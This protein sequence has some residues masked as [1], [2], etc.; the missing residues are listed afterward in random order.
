MR[1]VRFLYKL[2]RNGSEYARLSPSDENA[3]S[4]S[5]TRS[6]TKK[7]RFSGVFLPT[8][9]GPHG[10]AKEINWYLDEIQ[11]VLVVDGVEHPLSVIMPSNPLERG[12]EHTSKI[13]VVGYDRCA[14]V[15]TVH[16]ESVIHLSAGTLYTTAIKQ[17]LGAAGIYSVITT[18]SSATL[19][20]DREDWSVGTSLLK[21][22]NNLLAEINYASLWFDSRGNAIL[23]PSV[24]PSV[25]NINHVLSDRPRDSLTE[26]IERLLPGYSINTDVYDSPNVFICICSN[27]DKDDD[28]VAVA[29]NDDPKSPIST[30]SRGRRICKDFHLNNIASIE[31]LEAFANN[32]CIESMT[33]E[34]VISLTTAL[35]PGWGVYDVTAIHYENINAICSEESWSMDL[36]VGGEMRHDLKKVV[37]NIG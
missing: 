27:P 3:T 22:V 18:P 14:R 10:G 30:V 23:Q 1:R 29:V 16:A 31:D 12:G 19:Q 8:A 24:T 6:E 15:E 33:S 5:M 34:Q 32:R 17:I 13:A 37:Y 9:I 26:K 21:V 35:L 7:M 4:L 25:N 36:K 28:L 11:P 20:E 2:L